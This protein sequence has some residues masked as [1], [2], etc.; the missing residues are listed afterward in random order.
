MKFVSF[1]VP[2][3]M[4]PQIRTGALDAAGGIVDLAGA[5][6]ASLVGEGL[7]PAAAVRLSEFPRTRRRSISNSSRR[8]SDFV[9]FVRFVCLRVVKPS[10]RGSRMQSMGIFMPWS[11]RRSWTLL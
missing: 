2:T 3:P 11:D 9:A 5:C 8:W 7:A 4:G 6:R 10:A 1:S